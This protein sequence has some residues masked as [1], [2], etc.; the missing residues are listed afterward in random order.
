MRTTLSELTP[1]VIVESHGTC[2]LHFKFDRSNTALDPKGALLPSELTDPRSCS[3]VLRRN[4]SLRHVTGIRSRIVP[5]LTAPQS[6]ST[7]FTGSSRLRGGGASTFRLSLRHCYRSISCKIDHLFELVAACIA[8]PQMTHAARA[9]LFRPV[10]R[11]QQVVALF[12]ARKVVWVET[13]TQRRTLKLH[14]QSSLIE[15]FF[16]YAH[17]ARPVWQRCGA[18]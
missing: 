11:R 1:E 2:S 3:Q 14:R 17:C 4:C 12:A 6:V 13:V 7:R 5:M 16:G 8:Q 9:D 15:V 18:S 10:R